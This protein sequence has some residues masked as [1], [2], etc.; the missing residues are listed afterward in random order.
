MINI[1]IK[2]TALES[3]LEGIQFCDVSSETAK[4]VVDLLIQDQ[5]LGD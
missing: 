1:K 4:K 2:N 3:E 5:E